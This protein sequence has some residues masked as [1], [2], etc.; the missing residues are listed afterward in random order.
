LRCFLL[1][2]AGYVLKLRGGKRR[3]DL[4]VPP[5]VGL[6]KTAAE[7]KITCAKLESA[8]ILQATPPSPRLGM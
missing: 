6:T 7:K 8:V 1:G 2:T 3:E 4:S 5:V